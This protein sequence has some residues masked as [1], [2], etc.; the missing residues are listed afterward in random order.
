[1][2]GSHDKASPL[3]GEGEIEEGAAERQYLVLWLPYLS[4]DRLHRTRTDLEVGRPLVTTRTVGAGVFVAA[5]CPRAASDGVRAGVTLASA[6]ALLPDLQA[7][8]EAPEADAAALSRLAAWCDRY[9]PQVGTA[10]GDRLVIDATGCAHLFGGPR[11]ML[12]DARAR[13]MRAGFAVGGAFAPSPSAAAALTLYGMDAAEDGA[14]VTARRDL[15]AALKDLPVAALGLAEEALDAD[16]LQGLQRVGLRRL[17]DL[18]GL[19]RAALAARF[20]AGAASALDRLLGR[21]AQP[22]APRRPVSPYRIRLAFP[23]PI[24]L[25]GDIDAG[26]E[27]LLARLCAR[28]AAD[29]L[30][31]RRL[32]LTAW[33]ADGSSQTLALGLARPVRAPERLGRLLAEKLEAIDPGF[34]IDCLILEAPRVEPFETDQLGGGLTAREGARDA[35]A[36]AQLADRLANRMGAENS[37]RLAPTESRLPDAAQAKRPAIDSKRPAVEPRRPGVGRQPAEWPRDCGRP[38]RLLARPQVLQPLGSPKPGEPLL[39]FRLKGRRH[40]VRIALGPER[41]APDWWREDAAWAA[42]ARDYW[43]VEDEAGTRFWIYRDGVAGPLADALH[44]TGG[45]GRQHWYLHGVF[46]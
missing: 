37:F 28:L 36:L 26:V 35:D 29:A 22:I 9:S 17:G 10:G 3:K 19:P 32:A 11:A 14:V 15:A 31:C 30:G 41:I 1:M 13:L 33:R 39:A 21:S 6:R 44:G 24:G 45:A 27:R 12:A 40:A 23:D 5:L 18:Y 20:G 25:R 2:T 43:Q 8:A 34:G 46:E 16:A 4:T 42:G 7:V 38:L